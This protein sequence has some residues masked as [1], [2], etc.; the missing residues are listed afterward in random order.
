MQP[1]QRAMSVR[2]DVVNVGV[3]HHVGDGEAGAGTEHRGGLTEHEGL[4]VRLTGGGGVVVAF[5]APR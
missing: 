2:G 3:G 4:S 5:A 1:V